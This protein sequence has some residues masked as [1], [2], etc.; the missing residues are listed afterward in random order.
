MNKKWITLFPFSLLL[1][2][3]S[4]IISIEDAQK[5]YYEIERIQN[6][7]RISLNPNGDFG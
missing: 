4:Y 3:T 1:I 6:E 7:L 2:Q 5:N